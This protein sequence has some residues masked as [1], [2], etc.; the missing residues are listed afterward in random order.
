MGLVDR[1]RFVAGLPP[2][3]SVRRM[4]KHLESQTR[5]DANPDEPQDRVEKNDVLNTAPRSLYA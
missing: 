3:I 1:L 4:H 5:Q 2:E